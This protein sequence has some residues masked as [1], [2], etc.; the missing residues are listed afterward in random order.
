MAGLAP[1]HLVFLWTVT[2]LLGGLMAL[3]T[4]H[5][6]GLGLLWSVLLGPIGWFVVMF[7]PSGKKCPQCAER[8]K[9]AARAC[10]FC[11]HGF[12]GS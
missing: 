6:F 9:R 3:A 11:G 4:D 5:S 7:M 12:P 1:E 10:R 8:V 2:W